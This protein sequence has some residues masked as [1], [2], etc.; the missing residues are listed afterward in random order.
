[1]KRQGW[2]QEDS[3]GICCKKPNESGGGG[4]RVRAGEV[5]TTV[6]ILELETIG[7]SDGST[8]KAGGCSER[9]AKEDFRIYRP[10]P[11]DR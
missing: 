4:S 9:G 5:V 10:E 2:K 6:Y 7:L 8:L 1:M 11:V 3:L